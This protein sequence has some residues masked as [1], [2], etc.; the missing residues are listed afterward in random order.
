[1][2]AALACLLAFPVPGL[3]TADGQKQLAK[4]QGK[5]YCETLIKEGVEMGFKPQRTPYTIEVKGTA[6]NH[7]GDP[8][9][10]EVT[11]LDVR[12]DPMQIDL[13]CL[14]PK[15]HAGEVQRGIF[16]LSA[17]GKTLTLALP[18]SDSPVRPMGFDAPK[19]SG[20]VLLILKRVP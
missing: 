10:Y 3:L 8:A 15:P 13:K 20:R 11:G 2:T 1:M 16:T 5:W 17:D 7:A 19:E 4:L 18:L 12:S 14:A 9:R 6:W